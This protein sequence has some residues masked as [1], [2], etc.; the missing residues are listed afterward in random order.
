M[1]LFLKLHRLR[2]TPAGLGSASPPEHIGRKK[3]R[4][5]SFLEL[6]LVLP[7]I[8]IMLLGL[9][10]VSFFIASY[11]DTLDLTREAA[12]F[13]SVRDPFDGKGSDVYTVPSYASFDCL[14]TNDPSKFD[15][16]FMTACIFSPPL[17][18]VGVSGCADPKF[19]NGLNS[20]AQLNPLTDDIVISIFTVSNVSHAGSAG[21][22]STVTDQWPS[23][24]GYW[25]YS[26]DKLG[27][28]AGQ[29]NW[30]KDC[31]GT[32]VRTQPYYTSAVV[33]AAMDS[34]AVPTKGFVAIEYYYCYQQVLGIP[35]LTNF[36]P[37]PMRVHVY[38]LMPNP[39]AQPTDTP[40]P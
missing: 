36:I 9:V 40:I 31:S 21:G 34:A 4:G 5:Q 27:K 7:V 19:C 22:S 28:L 14:I 17:P 24:K 12:R 1:H 6:A 38:T 13:A 37:N 15:F 39:A 8:L 26:E 35:I 3:W 23:G 2:N 20:Y 11:L 25:S 30:T 32:N 18:Q 10:E 29:G 16:Y 33:N